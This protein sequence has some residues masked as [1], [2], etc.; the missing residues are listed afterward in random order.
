MALANKVDNG[1]L[2]SIS[3]ATTQDMTDKGNGIREL[4]ENT[5]SRTGMPE[6]IWSC[7]DLNSEQHDESKKFMLSGEPISK[8]LQD[9]PATSY[10]MPDGK[11]SEGEFD[12]QKEMQGLEKL[13]A[14]LDSVR[15][16]LMADI[17]RCQLLQVDL[18]TQFNPGLVQ[19]MRSTKLSCEKCEDIL[20]DSFDAEVKN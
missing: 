16:Q 8:T 13:S 12:Y 7:G 2:T 17:L 1:I 20:D 5:S 14:E 11:S 15:Q 18:A 4:F 6:S 10:G 3:Q 9:M 19:Q